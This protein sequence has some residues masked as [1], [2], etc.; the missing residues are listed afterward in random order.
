MV[1]WLIGNGW[2]LVTG[3]L[4]LFALLRFLELI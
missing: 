2:L 4:V 1:A 3:L